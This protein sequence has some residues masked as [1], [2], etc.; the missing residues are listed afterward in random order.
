MNSI[1]VE[2]LSKTYNRNKKA[3]NKLSFKVVQGTITGFVGRN[4]AGKTT[5][6]NI[7]A[8][9]LKP[10]N[11][12]VKIMDEIIKPGNWKYKSRVGFVLEKPNYVENLAG[13]QYLEFAS[14]MY[15]IN[16]IDAKN[17]IDEL[18]D[19]MELKDEIKKSIKEYSKGMKKK[20]SLATALINN[21]ELLILDE[22]LEGVDPVS[23]NNIKKLLGSL[24]EKG[25]TVFISSH[26]LGVIEKICDEIIIIEKGENIFAGTIN[27]LKNKSGVSDE[28]IINTSL[29]DLFVKLIGEST[30]Q[31]K[32]SWL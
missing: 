22:P 5:T 31:K 16:K 17:R 32:L 10:D 1:I 7:L 3:L 26:E 11:G 28:E 30:T 9:I 4:G 18:L 25:K 8:G 21:P 20:I 2:N 12:E 27:E 6:I 19:F 14:V 23:S 15:N 24:I 13:R 29:E